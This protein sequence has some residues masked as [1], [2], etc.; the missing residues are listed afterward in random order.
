MYG[1]SAPLGQAQGFEQR[2]VG[3]GRRGE[4]LDGTAEELAVVAVE[5]DFQV[6]EAAGLDDLVHGE[7]SVEKFPV[8]RAHG[9]RR[10][11]DLPL[12]R[13][14]NSV[15]CVCGQASTYVSGHRVAVTSDADDSRCVLC[16]AQGVQEI[17]VVGLCQVRAFME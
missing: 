3:R 13:R 5:E 16:C 1:E 2:A 12:F 8:E 17:L 9:V 4:S 14:K 6:I 10:V 7:A 11:V 15:A